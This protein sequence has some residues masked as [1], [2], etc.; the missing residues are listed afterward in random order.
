MGRIDGG[1]WFCYYKNDMTLGIKGILPY[2]FS[3]MDRKMAHGVQKKRYM[4]RDCNHRKKI[5]EEWRIW[6]CMI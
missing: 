3:V 6:T 4:R 2:G 5:M 1:G